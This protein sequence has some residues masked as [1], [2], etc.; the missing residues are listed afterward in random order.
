M[1]S[2]PRPIL[3]EQDRPAQEPPQRRL[4]TQ[5]SAALSKAVDMQT[6]TQITQVWSDRL[7]LISVYAS[8]FT[9]ID[10]LLF[11]L[12]SGHDE[13][14]SSAKLMLAC[15]SGA[16][17]FH[18]AAAILA[19]VGSFVLI[20]HKLS[21]AQ[22]PRKSSPRAVIAA[23]YAKHTLPRQPRISESTAIDDSRTPSAVE[24]GR[25]T[26]SEKAEHSVVSQPYSFQPPSANPF[27]S[28]SPT[29]TRLP[30]RAAPSEVLSSLLHQPPGLNIDMRR[31]KLFNFSAVVPCI[32]GSVDDDDPDADL[33]KN[34]TSLVHLL[35]RCHNVCSSFALAGFV[36]VVTG[37]VAYVWSVLEQ[38]VAIFGSTCVGVCLIFGFL[39]LR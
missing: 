22:V 17:I 8:F 24:S 19:Y 1:S 28:S 27:F 32:G 13:G 5:E 4:S 3:I 21:D 18:A 26:F 25:G 36:L 15:L 11:T 12:A 7:Q 33:Q 34:A 29:T 37:I 38:S 20:R 23:A 16:L 9:S 6:I 30:L 14:T 31:Q 2:V 10:S 39:A 35:N